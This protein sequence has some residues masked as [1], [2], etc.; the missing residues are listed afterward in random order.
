MYLKNDNILKNE[1]GITLVALVISIV[2]LLILAGVTILA[3]AGSNGILK[4]VAEAKN[5]TKK[6]TYR[7]KI[8][9]ILQNER[10]N[11]NN[12]N[13]E[14][15]ENKLKQDRE[16]KNSEYFYALNELQ[17]KTQEGWQFYI[18]QEGIKDETTL[19]E[20]NIADGNIEISNEG[21][22]QGNK[23]NNSYT[24]G[25]IIY[26]DNFEEEQENTIKILN[27]VQYVLLKNV[28]INTTTGG[29]DNSCIWINKSAELKLT[30]RE[31]NKLRPYRSNSAGI[32]VEGKL[33]ITEDSTGNLTCYDGWQGA[34]IGTTYGKKRATIEINGGNIIAYSGGG[35]RAAEIGRGNQGGF[36][37]VIINGGKINIVS[38]SV[39]GACIGS[40]YNGSGV[41]DRV[42]IRGGTIEVNRKIGQEMSKTC[43]SVEIQGGNIKCK[44][45]D[46]EP[47]NQENEKV[48]KKI[49]SG[50]QVSKKVKNI[51]F[52]VDYN[53]GL[54][55]MYT[56]SDGKLYLY[57]PS[58]VE[59]DKVEFE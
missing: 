6:A 29:K 18:T 57:L 28:N 9:L 40:G 10:I 38:D 16:L 3:L 47:I 36:V 43:A 20:L 30:L 31:E 22:K 27:G 8:N 35:G 13:L 54:K 14:E 53:Y 48:Y 41:N 19:V 45:V 12:I 11:N 52:N 26:S 24:G 46:P 5:A 33:D 7:E 34:A 15:V 49:V 44:E 59:V 42:I 50:L 39:Y 1:E 51:K 17:V 56:D 2:V 58:N 25:Y 37:T 4:Q 21:Y 32:A 23:E 55:D